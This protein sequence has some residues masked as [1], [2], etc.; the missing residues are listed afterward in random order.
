M[1]SIYF[2][3][4]LF[5]FDHIVTILE[6]LKDFGKKVQGSGLELTFNLMYNYLFPLSIFFQRLFIANVRNVL[7]WDSKHPVIL[8]FNLY[9][10]FHQG[11]KWMLSL[12]FCLE[13]TLK[14]TFGL[15]S[16]RKKVEVIFAE[17][18]QHS[19]LFKYLLVTN[20]NIGTFYS[21]TFLFVWNNNKC[22]YTYHIICNVLFCVT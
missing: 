22:D 20:L 2:L 21:V 9:L 10:S 1:Y 3:L 5:P 4:S 6:M 11:S 16:T 7:K 19:I 15:H 18:W 17:S 13:R 12:H 14:S 8:S